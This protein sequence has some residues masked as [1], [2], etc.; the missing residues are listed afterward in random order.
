MS[1]YFTPAEFMCHDGTAY[2]IDWIAARLGPLCAQLDYI[3]GVW[4]G[5]IRVL[6]GFRTPAYNRQVGGALHSYHMEGMAADLAP[7]MFGDFSPDWDQPIQVE[8]LY[9]LVNGLAT[10]GHLP[11]IKGIGHY[12]GRFI[13][14]DIRP[15]PAIVRWEGAGIGSEVA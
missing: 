7:I 2:P 5:P 9:R 8:R 15:T 4:G 11:L 14:L 10:D 1:K 6:S 13:H 12:P 3:R